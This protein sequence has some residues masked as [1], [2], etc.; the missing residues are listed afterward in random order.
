MART[1]PTLQIMELLL[2]LLVGDVALPPDLTLVSSKRVVLGEDG[3]GSGE[4]LEEVVLVLGHLLHIGFG[5]LIY[6]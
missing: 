1:E 2:V 6:S 5:P 4:F 3:E